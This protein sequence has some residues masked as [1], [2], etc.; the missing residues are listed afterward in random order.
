MH[1][2]NVSIQ[3]KVAEQYGVPITSVQP[4]TF[5]NPD[6]KEYRGWAV[7]FESGNKIIVRPS[8]VRKL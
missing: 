8:R 3:R 4:A 7:D 2:S 6:G 5:K 1:E